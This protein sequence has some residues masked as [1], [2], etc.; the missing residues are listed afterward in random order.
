MKRPIITWLLT[1]QVILINLE[2]EKLIEKGH[3]Q[4]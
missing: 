3:L 1:L 4:I 2:A